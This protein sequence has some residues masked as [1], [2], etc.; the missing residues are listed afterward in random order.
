LITTQTIQE[1]RFSDLEVEEFYLDN[2]HKKLIYRDS[3]LDYRFLHYNPVYEQEMPQLFLGNNGSAS[4]PLTRVFERKS[5]FDL[6]FHAWDIYAMSLDSFKWYHSNF[7]YSDLFFSNGPESVDFRVAAIFAVDLSSNWSLN[8]NYERIMETGFYSEQATK[9]SS[10]ALGMKYL[11]PKNKSSTFFNFITNIHQEE[12]NGGLSDTTYFSN[13]NNSIRIVI[14]VNLNG[15]LGRLQNSQFSVVNYYPLLQKPDSLAKEDDLKLDVISTLSYESGF[16]KYYDEG[17]TVK[18]SLYY[19]S[20]LVDEKGVRHYLSYDK[21]SISP[22]IQAYTFNA[23]RLK[24]GAQYDWWLLEQ[25]SLDRQNIH[26]LQLFGKMDFSIKEWV[27][28]NAKAQ[29][30]LGSY[31]GDFDLSLSGHI[32]VK[33]FLQVEATQHLQSSHPS[34]V[35]QNLFISSQVLSENAFGS[36]VRNHSQLALKIPRLGFYSSL[37]Y[38][39][40]QGHIYFDP[41]DLFQQMDQALQILDF[42]LQQKL[43]L[44]SFHLDLEGHLFSDDSELLDIPDFYLHSRLYYKG[45]ILNKRLFLN[46]G[47]ELRYMDGFYIPAYQATVGRFYAQNEFKSEAFPV[48]NFYIAFK[49]GNFRFFARTENILQAITGQVHYYSYLYPQND[50]RTFRMGVRWQFLN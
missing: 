1:A 38:D 13:P 47:F 33:D 34:I 17:N 26:D 29:Y 3:F 18:D 14:P 8:V 32:K 31:T 46:S 30:H 22:A 48:I 9:Q 21:I 16:F 5:G 24:L 39:R 20:L 37:T 25:E 44:Y 12:N 6:G 11:S 40:I 36:V 41:L 7:P 49:V 43:S 42:K 4:I 50:F 27:G 45:F 19:R 10:L 2:I 28:L 15:A 35:E 23:N